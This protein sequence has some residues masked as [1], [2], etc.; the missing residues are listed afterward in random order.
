MSAKGFENEFVY[1][2]FDTSIYSSC[3]SDPDSTEFEPCSQFLSDTSYKFIAS[4]APV[5]R[6]TRRVNLVK[7][8]KIYA[9]NSD[10]PVSVAQALRRENADEFMS[11]L[12]DEIERLLKMGSYD[13]F[14]AISIQ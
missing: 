5:S 13:V 4:S 6:R 9:F 14:W 2:F 10:S 3:P 1:Q 7:T 8:N 12:D 11:S